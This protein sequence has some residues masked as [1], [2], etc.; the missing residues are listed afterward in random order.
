MHYNLVL[1]HI[2]NQH[3]SHGTDRIN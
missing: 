3:S 2:I 1:A